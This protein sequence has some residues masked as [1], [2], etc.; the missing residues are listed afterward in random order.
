VS[1]TVL[2]ADGDLPRAKR[3][4]A[5]CRER[6]LETNLSSHGAA[7]LE[8]ALA[9]PPAALVVQLALPLIDGTQLGEILRAN[10]RTRDVGLLY[11]ADTRAESARPGLAGPI[12]AP[13]A[14]SDDVARQVQTLVEHWDAR[15]E[16]PA[17]EESGGVEGELS[18]LP[19]A[20]LLQ[21]FHVSQKTGV[22][23]V[24]RNA[25]SASAESGSVRICNGDIVSAELGS[26]SREKALFRLLAW[27]AGSFRF[28]PG[29]GSA[30]STLR[31]STPALLRDGRNQI[32]ELERGVESLPPLDATVRLKVRRASLPIVIHPLTQEVLLVLE[33]Y[34]R[35]RDVVE[36]CS[37]P[38]YSVLRT[39]QTL[40]ERDMVEVR[41]ESIGSAPAPGQELF[42]SALGTRLRD[43]LAA[44]RAAPAVPRD[45]RLLVVAAD[46]YASGEFRR[47]V[48]KLPGASLSPPDESGAGPLGSL[49]RLAVDDGV[50]IEM[51]EVPA[52]PRFAALWPLAGHGAVGI[53]LL[54]S[55]SVPEAVEALQPAAEQLSRLPRARVF[56][57]LLVDKEAG[58]ESE[59]LREQFPHFDDSSLFL[60]PVDK[61]DTADALLREMFVRIFP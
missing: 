57:L 49:G 27:N 3:L 48:E 15:G 43:W 53:L 38:D 14:D 22:I 6:G 40:I 46:S 58:L 19:L 29:K 56:H 18:Q 52:D 25:G 8:T 54:L 35:V 13:P 33:A 45:A 50:G 5:S 23:E 12:I 9:E 59:A 21:L 24:R 41:H 61:S 42:S 7:A 60:I 28:R 31:S 32:E 37:F 51:V 55:G 20:D 34:S 17:D 47:L 4:A 39:L 16:A 11:L 1:G 36:H 2:I 44:D 26:A 10:P 30:E